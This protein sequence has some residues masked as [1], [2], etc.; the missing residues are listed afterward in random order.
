MKSLIKKNNIFFLLPEVSVLIDG[1]LAA[2]GGIGGGARLVEEEVIVVVEGDPGF[3]NEA[4]FAL[5]MPGSGIALAVLEDVEIVVDIGLSTSL[6]SDVRGL[7][8][9]FNCDPLN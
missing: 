4:P 5:L 1:E 7:G 8:V 2:L 9:V 6:S 3:R